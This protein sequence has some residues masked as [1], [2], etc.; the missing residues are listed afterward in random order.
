MADDPEFT[1]RLA[2][3]RARV[4]DRVERMGRD[5]AELFAA[6]RDSN[7]DDEHDPEGQTIAYVRSQLTAMIE[8]ARGHLAEVD[9]ALARVAD[10]SYGICEVCEQ[11]IGAERLTAKPTSR[12]CV[13]HAP[14]GYQA[15]RRC[16]RQL[17]KR[18][19]SRPVDGEDRR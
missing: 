5:L 7:A 14:A 1:A 6:S 17:A 10:G 9:A 16:G 11:R 13:Q 15:Y 4:G 3:E 8:Q 18:E 12:T 19:S 2:E